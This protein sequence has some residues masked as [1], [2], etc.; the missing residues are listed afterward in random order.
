MTLP[1]EKQRAEGV[2]PVLLAEGA[3]GG[4]QGGRAEEGSLCTQAGGAQN[5]PAAS[6]RCL[7]MTQCL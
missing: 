1:A 6:E 5:K 2:A 7:R 3:A 4:L